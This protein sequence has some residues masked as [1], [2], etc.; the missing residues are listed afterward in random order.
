[1]ES[2]DGDPQT[3]DTFDPRDLYTGEGKAPLGSVCKSDEQ[4]ASDICA[5]GTCCETSCSQL[6]YRCNSEGHC[7]PVPA[8][9][10]PLSQCTKDAAST[11]GKDGYCDGKGACR[12]YSTSTT[13]QTSCSGDSIQRKKCDGK[14]ACAGSTTTT[15]CSPYTCNSSTKTCYESCSADEQCAESYSCK[16]QSCK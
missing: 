15:N 14:G 1:M 7:V 10:D 9:Q 8:G 6:C 2:G 13:C 16:G 3:G 5:N 4:C 11:C 12:L